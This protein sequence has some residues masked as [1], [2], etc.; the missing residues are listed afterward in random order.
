MTSQVRATYLKNA[1][2]SSGCEDVFTDSL[3]HLELPD[4]FRTN[5]GLFVNSDK[6]LI[7][8]K[9]IEIRLRP[10]CCSYW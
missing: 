4:V 5:T 7:I 2:L 10:S 8:D 9:I 1:L 6:S 3:A